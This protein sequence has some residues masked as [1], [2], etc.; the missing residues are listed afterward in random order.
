MINN[1]RIEAI[2]LKFIK[3]MGSIESV[4]LHTILFIAAFILYFMGIKFDVILLTLTTI[5]SLEAIYFSIFIQ[6]SLNIQAK[7][8]NTMAQLQ[9]DIQE[10]VEEI[11]ENVEEIQEN[12]E[13]IQEDMEDIQKDV[14][15]IQKDVEEINEDDD[16][17][18]EDE[19][20]LRLE[21]S[22]NI[23]MKEIK[24]LKSQHQKL[25]QQKQK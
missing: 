7:K 22:M 5:V 11:Q 8:I 9:E 12:M 25:Q 6:M 4:I 24:Y 23:M 18:N 13:D 14:E 1:E 10:D 2:A 16:D 3:W 20:L 19:I 21:K 17:D 15:E